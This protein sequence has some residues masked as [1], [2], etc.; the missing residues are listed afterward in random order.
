[1]HPTVRLALVLIL[2]GM[3][4]LAT[5]CDDHGTESGI[6]QVTI[7]GM[8]LDTLRGHPVTGALV[9]LDD[10]SVVTATSDALGIYSAVVSVR[11]HEVRPVTVYCR[12]DGYRSE[13]RTVA[14]GRTQRVI[15]GVDFRLWPDPL[16]ADTI[17][18]TG[19]V[20]DSIK[21]LPLSGVTVHLND[22]LGPGVAPDSMGYYCITSLVPETSTVALT[23]YGRRRGYLTE[24]RNF[25]TDHD[26]RAFDSV[27]FPMAHRPDDYPVYFWG[28]IDDLYGVYRV[29]S[30]LL[31]TFRLDLE[32]PRDLDVSADGSLLYIRMPQSVVVV[33]TTTLLT[34]TELP[35]PSL[36]PVAVSPDGRHIALQTGDLYI[37][38]TSDY[39]VVHND[40]DGVTNGAFSQD[41]NRFYADGGSDLG[42]LIYKVDLANDFAVTRTYVPGSYAISM[43]RP[44]R[45][46]SLWFLYRNVSWDESRFDVYDVAIDSIIFYDWLSPG[47]GTL[48]PSVDSDRM[49]STSPGTLLAGT[50][51]P[52]A[53][54]AYNIASQTV[55]SVSIA[56]DCDGHPVYF[57]CGI[58]A[59]TPDGRFLI[60]DNF[61]YGIGMMIYDLHADSLDTCVCPP[62]AEYY[63]SCQTI[64]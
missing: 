9:S 42:Q 4:L 41:G 46:E 11:G 2:A 30:R 44:S 51:S 7:T 12:R 49:F 52:Y 64:P 39:S 47:K 29:Q 28:G 22:T 10:T 17:V 26:H 25:T 37:L 1:M 5:A 16:L 20:L 18:V 43:M 31:D 58:L 57:R 40:T 62:C 59:V 33:S 50:P 19:R 63:L 54:A 34:V 45:D 53:F 3:I 32:E 38:R 60:G 24:M 21:Q 48:L 55:D 15:S 36:W 13:S 6:T 56:S 14:A 35:Y 8:V 27:D 23:V 61:N